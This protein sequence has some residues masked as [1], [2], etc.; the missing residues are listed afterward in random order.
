MSSARVV[1]KLYKSLFKLAHN[2]DANSNAKSILYRKAIESTH[3]S[4]AS[5][6]Y[7]TLLDSFFGKKNNLFQ[8]ENA[9][10]V[11]IR[12]I[13]RHEFR[14]KH[15]KISQ[16]DRV[17]VAFAFIRSLSS[18]WDFYLSM[19]IESG[20]EPQIV[21]EAIPEMCKSETLLPGIFLLAHPMVQGPLQRSVVLLLEHNTDG[22]YG[23]VINKDSTCSLPEA[24]KGL[25]DDML[26]AFSSATVSFGGM[27]R[28]LQSIHS[29]QACG[30]QAIPMCTQDGQLFSSFQI[31]VAASHVRQDPALV[32][33][34]KFF[35]GCC[36]WDVGVLEN[37][38]ASGFWITVQSVPD[39]VF[40]LQ[41]SLKNA[42]VASVR[43]TDGDINVLLE[44]SGTAATN[45]E[46]DEGEED[47]EVH[48]P[49]LRNLWAVMMKSLGGSFA[50]V[51]AF[52]S[53]A[54]TST[55]E[56]TDWK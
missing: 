49:D 25:P 50:E 5:V 40:A 27:F 17:D 8:P 18:R 12:S 51:A 14:Q 52:P 34:F 55:V 22:T 3:F 23:V 35:V 2:F 47:F 38:I 39:Q 32:E 16:T 45:I 36:K 44:P 41:D 37:E 10:K 1:K 54:N 7:G 42:E 15:L 31:P 26:E 48:D 29:V 21:L 30:G 43:S 46:D 53:W 6:Y 24:V 9:N 19:G 56:S 13:L 20:Q 33:K 4:A 28:R 11:S